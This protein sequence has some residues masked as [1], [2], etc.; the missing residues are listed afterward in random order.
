MSIHALEQKR[1]QNFQT[2]KGYKIKIYSSTFI[3]MKYVG[4]QQWAF[5]VQQGIKNP[6]TCCKKFIDLP[7]NMVYTIGGLC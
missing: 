5:Y 6:C 7:I 4:F 2:I 3:S 1:F